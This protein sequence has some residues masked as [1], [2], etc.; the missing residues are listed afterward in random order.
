MGF[1]SLS[2]DADT[3]FVIRVTAYLKF[4]LLEETVVLTNALFSRILKI[5]N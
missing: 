4:D 2:G 3:S 5:F 1:V